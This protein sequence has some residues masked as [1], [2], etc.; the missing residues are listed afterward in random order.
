MPFRM[1]P[2]RDRSI[3]RAFRKAPE[4]SLRRGGVL[5]RPH[6]EATEVF[7][8]TTGHLRLTLFG[9]GRGGVG[10][11]SWI[12]AIVGPDEVVGIDAVGQDR[13]RYGA[14]AAETTRVKVLSAERFLSV[15]RRAT[16]SLPVLLDAMHRDLVTARWG[17]CA[18][19]PAKARIARS[20]VELDRRFGEDGEEGE[21]RLPKRTTHQEIAEMAGVHRSTVTTVLNDWIYTGILEEPKGSRELVLKNP[22][23]LRREALIETFDSIDP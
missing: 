12:S 8:V 21:R 16:R 20:L 18:H 11:A 23:V 14:I 22:T 17:L 10:R 2:S 19:A 3:Y 4:R 6:D 9:P 7:L 15:L 5:Y 1:V 13:R